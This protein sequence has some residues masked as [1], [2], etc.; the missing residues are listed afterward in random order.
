MEIRT[1]LLGV[2]NN[3][4]YMNGRVLNNNRIGINSWT[5][6]VGSLGRGFPR[7]SRFAC[8]FVVETHSM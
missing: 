3:T 6:H 5:E 4:A 7:A 1:L 2:L 8:T